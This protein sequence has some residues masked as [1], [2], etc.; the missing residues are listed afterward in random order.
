VRG[1]CIAFTLERILDEGASM[2]REHMAA[3]GDFGV[4]RADETPELP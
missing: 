2:N 3:T 4:L 1:L